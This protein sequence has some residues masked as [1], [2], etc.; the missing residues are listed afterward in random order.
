M[1]RRPRSLEILLRIREEMAREA[2]FDVDL[3]VERLRSGE[4]SRGS[5]EYTL[6]DSVGPSRRR[7]PKR[8]T[9]KQK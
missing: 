4:A 1:Y 7:S 5:D 6:D 2:D 8:E 9:G 3:F